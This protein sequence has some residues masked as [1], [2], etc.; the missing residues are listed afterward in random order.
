MGSPRL[1]EKRCARGWLVRGVLLALW[2]GAG[3]ALGCRNEELG[4]STHVAC[5]ADELPAGNWSRALKVGELVRRYTLY[6]PASRRTG[7]PSP[8]LFLF[9]GGGGTAAD[10][11][12]TTAL[13]AKAD[14]EGFLLALPEGTESLL[15]QQIWNAGSC[16]G[17]AADNEVD[18]VGFV[19]AMIDAT[20]AEVCVDARRVYA[21]GHSNGGMLS[22]RLACELAD[23]IAAVAPN[24]AFLMDKDYGA[25]PPTTVFPC[26]PSR[27]VPVMH[28]HGLADGC[29]SFEGGVGPTDPAARPPVEDV[30]AGWVER[31]K[32]GAPPTETYRNGGAVCV[33][34]GGCEQGADVVLCTVERNGH[35]WP[36][37][38]RY[39]AQTQ[40][41][42]GG[43]LT[44]ELKATDAIWDFLKAHPLPQ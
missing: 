25:Q 11:E 39:P 35:V 42:C 9:H 24:A 8:L 37:G 32:C 3:S 16:C 41:Q 14:A 18:D 6:V 1:V 4:P 7:E 20:A 36:G 23:R 33:S 13:R 19:S 12:E 26:N 10:I 29:A 31:N 40:R 43:E 30:I 17:R 44:A 2:L 21:T 27:P 22:Y 15:G 28:L 38:T 34:H 5:T